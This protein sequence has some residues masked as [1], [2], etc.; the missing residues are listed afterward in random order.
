MTEFIT[1]EEIKQ[2]RSS[3][4]KITLEEYAAR[5][6]KVIQEAKETHDIVDI[7]NNQASIGGANAG[8]NNKE[9]KFYPKPEKIESMIKVPKSTTTAPKAVEVPKTVV[10]A[11]EEVKPVKVEEPKVEEIKIE[12]I[13]K[14]EKIEQLPKEEKVQKT[15][16][17][18]PKITPEKK[19]IVEKPVE[20]TSDSGDLI[21]TFKKALTD[22]EQSVL[23]HLKKNRGTIVFAKDLAELLDLKRDYIYKYIKNLRSKIIE[24][25]LQNSEQGGFFLK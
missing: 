21:I 7:L 5:L 1:K 17:K 8:L 24:D 25:V 15:E 4:E 20:S 13:K 23:E 11:T 12:E 18:V 14:P 9:T 2:W 3:V 16:V 6:G 19:E 22:R 10:K